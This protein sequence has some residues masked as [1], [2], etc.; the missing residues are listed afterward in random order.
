[1]SFSPVAKS[2]AF[3]LTLT[4]VIVS[5][6]EAKVAGWV[7]LY[8]GN[9]QHFTVKD[10][11]RIFQTLAALGIDFE[12]SDN[13]IWVPAKERSQTLNLLSKD[14]TATYSDANREEDEE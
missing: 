6:A 10:K 9:E 14:Y 7:S 5:V 1:M 12:D 13:L 11:E 3:L 8:A 4:S 2:C